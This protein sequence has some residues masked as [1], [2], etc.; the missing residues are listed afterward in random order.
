MVTKNWAK[1][2]EKWMATFYF[3]FIFLRNYVKEINRRLLD[4]YASNKVTFYQISS[5]A[6]ENRS[7][8]CNVILFSKI[9]SNFLLLGIIV[10]VRF[11]YSCLTNWRYISHVISVVLSGDIE[12]PRWGDFTRTGN[13]LIAMELTAVYSAILL[14]WGP[15]VTDVRTSRGSW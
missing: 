12:F 10:L 3:I 13:C 8:S 9:Y 15:N 14:S 11:I 6:N 7:Y 5:Q 4:Y 2:T 1:R